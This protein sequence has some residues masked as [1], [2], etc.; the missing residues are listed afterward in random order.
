[1]AWFRPMGADS[2]A[3][4]SSTVLGRGDDEPG[5]ALA[6]YGSRGE[7]PLRWGGAG[8][9]RLGLEGEVTPDAYASTFGPGGA[10]LDGR[11]LVRAERPGFELVVAAHKSVAVAGLVDPDAMHSILDVET[12]ATMA[13]LDSWFAERGGRRGREQYRTPTGGLTYAVTRHGTT[14][15]GDP[16]PHDH[17]LVANVVEMLDRK[18]GFKGLDSAALRDTVEAATMVGRLHSAARAVELGFRITRDDGPSGRLRHWRI[19]GV[20]VEV[21]ELFSKRADEIAEA[22]EES[23]HGTYRAANIAARDSRAPKRHTGVDQLVPEWHRELAELGWPIERLAAHLEAH[24]DRTRGL[25]FPMTDAELD[26]L[27]GEVLDVDGDLLLDHKAFTRTNLTAELAPRLYGRDPTELDRALDRAI[28]SRDVVPL[29]RVAGAREQAYTTA[30]VLENEATIRTVVGWLA[31]RHDPPDQGPGTD[32]ERNREHFQ[33]RNRELTKGQ[34]AAVEAITSGRGVTVVVGVAGSGK[35]TAIDTAARVLEAEGRR[36]VGTSTS[37]QA[38]RNL[39]DGA[40]IESRTLAS[41]LARLERGTEQLDRSTV[42]VVDEAGMVADRDLARLLLA[43][44]RSGASVVLVGDPR[45]LDPVGP[46]GALRTIADTHPDVVVT[47]NANVRQANTSEREALAHL[48]AGDVERALDWYAANDRIVVNPRRVETLV[49]AAGAWA[50]DIA[51]GHDTALLAWRREDVADLNRLARAHLH[52]QGRLGPDVLVDGRPIAVG[53]HL[54]AL[55]PNHWS[56]LVTSQQIAVTH[57]TPERVHA[58]TTDGRQVSI[59]GEWLDRAHLDHAYAL[60]V[61]RAQGATYDRA[62]VLA[63][64]GGRELAYVAMS[65]ARDRTTIHATADTPAQ[66]VEDLRRD[67]ATERAQRWITSLDPLEEARRRVVELRQ[68]L[69]DLRVGTGRWTDTPAGSAARERADA[70]K[71][72]A[73]ARQRAEAPGLS[74]RERRRAERDLEPATR[75][76][77]DACRRWELDGAPVEAELLDALA[78]AESAQGHAER[79][80]S[81]GRLRA[82]LQ[83]LDFKPPGHELDLGRQ[84]PPPSIERD[85]GIGL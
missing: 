24:R 80:A 44:E 36:V 50:Q 84:P 42:V 74:R 57:V 1:M 14:R 33:E 13:W 39:G 62:H 52:R 53:D 37:G 69:S 32:R 63:A 73:A 12:E 6:Y 56:R 71:A 18:G 64:G 3:Y 27:L 58:V 4:H 55:A 78:T 75:R 25:S 34:Q 5:R 49:E 10:V 35:T 21:C 65:R 17:V 72:L 31:D 7:T 45:Q 85:F 43:V 82:T 8:A 66:A 70:D 15:A 76:V 67:W 9:E 16:G 79:V 81:T 77:A 51:N 46:G 83:H 60:T 59:A 40:G 61:H 68:D 20:P 48:R 30:A 23:G 54:V 11:R 38:A 47:L 22:L 28:G 2:V 19:E 26:R 41:L 29:I